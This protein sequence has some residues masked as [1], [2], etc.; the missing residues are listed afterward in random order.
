MIGLLV[1]VAGIRFTYTINQYE[2]QNIITPAD[3]A[4]DTS[5]CTGDDKRGAAIT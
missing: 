3:N 4:D 1:T 5:A 2:H